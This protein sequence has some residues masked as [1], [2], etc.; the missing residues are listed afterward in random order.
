MIYLRKMAGN[1]LCKRQQSIFQIIWENLQQQRWG[2][3]IEHQNSSDKFSTLLCVRTSNGHSKVVVTAAA[4]V[5]LCLICAENSPYHI[6]QPTHHLMCV[7]PLAIYFPPSFLSFHFDRLPFFSVLCALLRSFLC[8]KHF[9]LTFVFLF[10]SMFRVSYDFTQLPSSSA[11][12][13]CLSNMELEQ[14]QQQH[15]AV[16]GRTEGAERKFSGYFFSSSG[17]EMRRGR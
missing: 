10:I 14:Q 9:F 13:F 3:A 12:L 2:D 5:I 16:W 6:S 17:E 11:C 8:E 15:Q 7:A 1:Y 4:Y